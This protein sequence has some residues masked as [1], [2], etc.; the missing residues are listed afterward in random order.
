M[1]TYQNVFDTQ[2]QEFTRL[3]EEKDR[4]IKDIERQRLPYNEKVSAKKQII[5]IFSLNA[6]ELRSNP[7]Y[8]QAQKLRSA[9][10][11]AKRAYEAE[12][13]SEEKVEE[14]SDCLAI[15]ENLKSY[16]ISMEEEGKNL[17]HRMLASQEESKDTINETLYRRW[18]DIL[19]YFKDFCSWW[20]SNNIYEGN[21][22]NN[23]III[24]QVWLK[25]IFDKI[26]HR[27]IIFSDKYKD[28]RK[29][30]I[31]YFDFMV[32]TFKNIED[33]IKYIKDGWFSDEW[34]YNDI[35]LYSDSKRRS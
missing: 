19:T 32:D 35:S 2:I 14:Q 34:E 24:E 4:K 21:D 29:N 28:S 17:I 6:A 31:K 20:S 11:G 30:G 13:Q 18:Q 8:K 1:T 16:A 12:E 22:R 15:C 23:V 10:L 7:D 33:T 26:Y 5:D 27:C 9:Y 25:E 3:K